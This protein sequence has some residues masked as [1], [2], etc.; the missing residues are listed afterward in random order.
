MNKWKVNGYYPANDPGHKY[1]RA[2]S[3]TKKIGKF[4]GGIFW[5]VLLAGGIALT[6]MLF[7][8]LISMLIEHAHV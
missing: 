5:D 2:M 4:L 3:T 1:D 7:V 6:I 8:T